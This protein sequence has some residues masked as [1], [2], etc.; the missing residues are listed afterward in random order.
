MIKDGVIIFAKLP[1]KDDL[2]GIQ[3]CMEEF[4]SLDV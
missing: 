1:S 2:G 3:V 4:Y